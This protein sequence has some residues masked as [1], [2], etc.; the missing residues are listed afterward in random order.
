MIFHKIA[1]AQAHLHSFPSE[2]CTLSATL[3]KRTQ[4]FTQQS[5]LKLNIFT[6]VLTQTAEHNL[7]GHDQ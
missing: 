7:Q 1:E 3:P 6:A 2:L 4:T 5:L